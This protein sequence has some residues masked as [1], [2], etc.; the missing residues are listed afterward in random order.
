[1]KENFP[2]LSHTQ[3]YWLEIFLTCLIAIGS[4]A[5]LMCL[6]RWR[7]NDGWVVELPATKPASTPAKAASPA[8]ATASKASPQLTVFFASQKGHG[9]KFA[10]RLVGSARRRGVMAVAA[11]LSGYDADRLVEHR[12]A[13]FIAATYA[14]GTAVPGTEAFF[15]ECAEMSRDFRV[16]KT[17][18]ASLSFAVFGCGN[19]EY[20]AKEFNA[21]ARK[22]DRSLRLLGARRLLPRREG[23]DVDNELSEQFDA[24]MPQFWAAYD[25][26]VGPAEGGGAA[27]AAPVATGKPVSKRL[28]RM[29]LQAEKDAAVAAASAAR[30]AR[31][32]SLPPAA[33]RDVKRMATAAASAL[34]GAAAECCGGEGAE[35]ECCGSGGG[36]GGASTSGGG[37]GECCGGKGGSADCECGGGGEGEGCCGGGGGGVRDYNGEVH[38]DV[39]A[40]IESDDEESVHGSE[41]G[42]GS[43]GG[44]GMVDLEDLGSRMVKRSD[45]AAEGGELKEMV[46]PSLKASLQKQGYKIVGSHSG[47]KLCRWTKSM[48][49]GRGGCYKHTFYGIVSYQ[50]MEATPSLACANKCV[51]CWRHHD[52]PVGTSFR[53]KVDEPEV[54]LDGF[55]RE[56]KALI[57]ACKG[58][59]GVRPERLAEATKQVRHCALS[60]VGEP[61]IYP[62]I[63][64]FLDAMHGRGI[65]SF[66]VTN[67]Q[68]PE[69]METLRPCTQLYISVDAP[70]AAELK[71]VD[72]PLFPDFWER[73]LT[74]VDMLREKKQRTVF[75]MTLV[76]GWNT[77][78]LD[79]YV[80]LVRRAQP[81]FVEVKGV[82]YCGDSKASP[83][84]I[85]HCPFHHEVRAYCAAMAAALGAGYE[86]ASEH[87]HSNI[88]LLAK[89]DFKIGGRWHTWID[90][91]KFTALANGGEPFGALDYCLPT[92]EWA[93]W[94]PAAADGGFDPVET[95]FMRKPGAKPQGGC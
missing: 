58:V 67:A 92:P 59:P 23:D 63:N 42:Y 33:G 56:H 55:E 72:R 61:I 82:T 80:E 10:H 70:T 34:G 8:A 66:M 38:A 47:V 68:F 2:W 89:T 50:C 37:D 77:E 44:E 83:L 73:F 16:E 60:L 46:T 40:L 94:D 12:H 64:E 86:V 79:K 74:C 24:W 53:W 3:A 45:G 76:N 4:S 27:A 35:G 11:D 21:S 48:L 57:R 90:Y 31:E 88:V 62:R 87:A 69:Q 13:V 41:G 91:D 52:N 75:R 65:S 6:A 36:G 22:L 18:L 93:C 7:L 49:R 32:F 81:D 5:L 29:R 26:G 78:Q 20:P 28:E 9:K 95:R 25:A 51:F 39:G 17:L 14:G 15:D 84:T 30:R 1:M 85:K 19:S 71:A 54:L 43:E